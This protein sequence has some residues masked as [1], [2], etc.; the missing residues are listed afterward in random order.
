MNIF[1]EFSLAFRET[2]NLEGRYYILASVV[3]L[4]GV[5]VG[6]AI[7]AVIATYLAESLGIEP[8]RPLREEPN[9]FLWLGVFITSIPIAIYLGCAC[10]AGLFSVV[11]VSAGKFTKNEAVRYALLS[12]YPAAWL[13]KK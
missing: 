2:K 11:M 10:V 8:N 6:V 12:R 3:G 7:I 4:A 1:R 5:L 9:G 13:R